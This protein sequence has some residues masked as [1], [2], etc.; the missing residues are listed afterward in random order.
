MD[1]WPISLAKAA[2]RLQINPVTAS[3]LVKS[4]GIPVVTY[5]GVKFIGLSRESFERL[6][7][8]STPFIMTR[9]SPSV[10]A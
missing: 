7:E 5:P 10:P 1:V 9:R 3:V 2:V 8:L 4:H 6:Q